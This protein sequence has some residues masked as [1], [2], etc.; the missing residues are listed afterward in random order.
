L[1]NTPVGDLGYT[2]D[3]AGNRTTV[4]GSLAR[5]GLPQPVS[6]TSYDAA[7]RLLVWGG[8]G[9][10]YDL[11]GNLASDG[12]TS[13]TW[14]ARNQLVGLSGATSASFA[15][16]GTNRRRGKSVNGT[17]TDFLYDGF[18]VVQELASGGM[19]NANLVAGAID[20]TFI[21]TDQ[22]GVSTF[23]IDALGSALALADDSGA[24]Q[25]QYTFV[26][27]GSTTSSGATSTNAQ[28]FTRRENDGTDLYY[29]RARYV[30]P[31]VSR[32]VSEDPPGF[33]GGTNLYAFVSNDP[34][35]LID[36][37]GLRPDCDDRPCNEQLKDILNVAAEIARRYQQYANPTWLLPLRGP[38]SRAG[39]IEQIDVKQRNLRKRIDNYNNSN[40]P[41]PIPLPVLDLAT[42]PL[43]KLRPSPEHLPPPPNAQ[44]MTQ[45][46]AALTSILVMVG[47][48]LLAF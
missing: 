48:M 22:A 47:S 6:A 7:N 27:F 37:L 39:H 19:P 46:G 2:Y 45:I 8:Q 16:D 21:R 1:N 15:Y 4:T 25:T 43:P 42:R 26:P 38:N 40:C 32:F 34:V 30:D 11:N 9:L 20:D 10:S 28:Q 36:P 3:L 24:I 41:D 12:L 13:Y 5:T 18:N 29:F 23:L 35:N 17:T 33:T 14:N 31:T 44:Q